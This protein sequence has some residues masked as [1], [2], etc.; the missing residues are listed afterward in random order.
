MVYGPKLVIILSFIAYTCFYLG[1]LIDSILIIIKQK[2]ITWKPVTNLMKFFLGYVF[3]G[4][5]IKFI[6][7]IF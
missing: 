4:I 1:G 2:S 6:S 7:S 5:F 3:V